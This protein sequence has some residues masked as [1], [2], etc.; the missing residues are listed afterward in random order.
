[1]TFFL[2]KMSFTIRRSGEAHRRR[3]ARRRARRHD[4]RRRPR[5][6]GRT[7]AR[8]RSRSSPPTVRTCALMCATSP[9]AGRWWRCVRRRSRVDASGPASASTERAPDRS[10]TNR[11]PRSA[12][13]EAACVEGQRT[14]ERRSE[15]RYQ[16]TSSPLTSGSD[17]A[18]LVDR[19]VRQV[20]DADTLKPLLLVRKRDRDKPSLAL[21]ERR[22]GL[23]LAAIHRRARKWPRSVRRPNVAETERKSS[24]LTP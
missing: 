12:R 14:S 19:E 3:P 2:K 20:R 6:S 16:T 18:H 22:S 23:A 17:V 8:R 9:L 4:R 15:M 1:M 21:L 13:T 7:P 24:A 10:R 5:G 11:S